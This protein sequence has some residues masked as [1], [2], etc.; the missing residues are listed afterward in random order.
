MARVQTPPILS[1]IRVARSHSEL[2]GA[3]RAL[4]DDVIG[5]VQR[6]EKWVEQ[7]I[8]EYLVKN[9]QSSKSPVT[10]NGDDSRNPHGQPRPLTDGERVRLLSLDLIAIF[11]NGGPSFFAPLEAADAIPAVL[12]HI[13]PA[14][15]QPQV[16]LEALQALNDMAD[17]A[18]LG[19][20][21][22]DD[23]S[24]LSNLLFKPA[25]LAS[26]NRILASTSPLMV[27]QK[28]KNLVARLISRLCRD[29]HHQ[30]LLASHGTLNALAMRLA[31][32]V[33]LRGEVIP[34]AEVPAFHD[35]LADALQHR[36]PP[37][38]KLGLVLEAIST[39]IADS[40]FR[41]GMLVYSPAMM[42][43]FPN[44]HFPHHSRAFKSA[45]SALE[46][47]NLCTSRF[48]HSSAME[49]LL[50]PVPITQPKV[51]SA[52]ITQF[53]PLG[54]SPSNEELES[55]A[56][57]PQTRFFGESSGEVE[58][59]NA[60]S[61]LIPWLIHL[62]R[63]TEG[64][65][66]VMAASVLASLY[67]AGFAVPEREI[68]IGVLVVPLLCQLIKDD[69]P[70]PVSSQKSHFVD[71][72]TAENW[73]IQERTP[74][75]LARLVSDSDH[76]QQAAVDCGA[77]KVIPKLLKDA[78]E[79]LPVQN[80]PRPWLPTPDRADGQE[81]GLPTCRLGPPGQLPIAAHKVK[82]RESMLKLVAGLGALKEEYRKALA[83]EDVLPFVVES[84]T[85]SPT[86]P[87]SSKEK[88][89]GD[90]NTQVDRPAENS[91]YGTNPNTVI[92]AACHAVRVLSRS[93][94]NLR[95]VLEDHGVAMPVFRLLKHP[96]AE[97]QIAACG[98]IC[99]LVLNCSPL[100]EPLLEAGVLKVLC[101]HAQSENPGL[102]LNAMWA[103]K[104]LV[105][106]ADT[107]LK[108]QA[109]EEL[110]PGTLVR[111]ILDDTE[112]AA[113][114]ARAQL[115]DQ[116]DDDMEVETSED[117]ATI[118]GT[119]S[120]LRAVSVRV[121][122][123]ERKLAALRDAELNPGRKARNDDLAIQEQGLNFI[124]NLISLPS[125]P[126]EMVDHIF[127]EIGQDRLFEILASKFR[128]KV[129]HPFGRKSATGPDSRVLY[130][131][132]KVIEAVVYVL[133]NIAASVPRHRQLVISQ[134]ELLKLLSAQITSRDTD[135]RRALCHLLGNLGE[136][137]S[138]T[139]ESGG[140]QRADELKR[141]GFLAKLAEMEM[142]DTDLD[143]RERAKAAAWKI[144]HPAT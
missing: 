82:M 95:T 67:K 139:D 4:K 38:A 105:E 133:V 42:A 92:I 143:V 116:G 142:G 113:L 120:I 48:L 129:L 9:L 106:G 127:N 11:A 64:L 50:P 40:R 16:V 98:V 114:I 90:K 68:A 26:I 18:L 78:Y 144:K 121:Q 73:A 97:V 3:L 13:S 136:R 93:V 59:D 65:E 21:G 12:S 23:V 41:A 34:G 6:K 89:K 46:V 108:K 131:Q 102:R 96:V 55:R 53:P 17:A 5:H 54:Y 85:A 62:T 36:A 43:V 39:I 118:P 101:E 76:L 75:V 107:H 44:I 33:V 14:D 58:N 31:S 122:R 10:R 20:A 88:T 109:L 104:A 71:P 70:V 100:R 126:G 72:V 57:T 86:R 1:Q 63:S 117:D 111:L 37:G 140:A 84:L 138:D 22:G 2:T 51:L 123:A 103:L 56:A 19:R 132:A 80:A 110:G 28:Q 60:E 30:N 32:F 15:N 125:T 35:G 141:L 87:R 7:G 74:A 115:Q 130:P 47:S 52:Q 135:V 29:S 27:V 77:L 99:N 137:D 66:R 83:T 69:K 124:R 128:V 61:P 134:T 8:L 79:P 112:D 91:P 119:Q 45:W 25:H 24:T 81:E 94:S 49:C